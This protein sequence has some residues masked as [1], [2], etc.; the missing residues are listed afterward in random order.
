MV[1]HVFDE[2]RKIQKDFMCKKSI[3]V[4]GM[5]YFEQYLKDAQQLD[6]ISISVHC[7]VKIF[8]WLM[9]YVKEGSFAKQTCTRSLIK[10]VDTQEMTGAPK[11]DIKYVISILISSEF[12]GMPV[13]VHECI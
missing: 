10:E 6:D 5:K 7:D 11:L 3:L 1:I 12:L 8:D 4:A 2:Q 9:K 13:L